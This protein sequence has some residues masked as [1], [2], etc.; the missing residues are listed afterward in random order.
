[1]KEKILYRFGP[2]SLCTEENTLRRNNK[3]IPATPKMV[4]LLLVLL[5][6]QG[7]VLDKEFLLENV[8]P[9]SFVEEGNISFNIRQLRKALD[10]NAQSPAFIE[11]VP[12]RGYRFIAEVEMDSSAL[13]T[14]PASSKA[15][16]NE[17]SCH[18][19]GEFS[20]RT[21]YPLLVVIILFLSAAAIGSFYLLKGNIDAAPVLSAPFASEKLSTTGTVFGSAIS[22]DG[23]TVVFSIRTGEKQSVWLR[24]LESGTNVELIP[25]SEEDYYEFTYSPDGDW[26]YFSRGKRDLEGTIEIFRI[27]I[28]GGI[29]EKVL[30]GTRG[31]V[32]ISPDGKIISFVRCPMLEKEWCSLYVADAG[33]GQNER[34]LISYQYPI[35]IADNE[36]SPDGMRIAYAYGQS[37]NQANAFSI[38]EIDLNEGTEKVITSERFF[39][40]KNICWLPDGSGLLLSA[41]RI[42]NKHFRI[43]HLSSGTETAEPL[44]NDSEAYSVLSLDREAKKLIS[45]QIKQDFRINVF[46]IED[47]SEKYF[48]TDASRA[49]FA[50]D[51]KV[52]FASV[53]SGNDEIWSINPDGSGRRQLTNDPGGDAAPVVSSDNK[54]VF[55]T[56]NRSGEAHVWK[57]NADGTDQIQI[58][59][60]EGGS[61]IFIAPDGKTVY[62]RHG[63][64]GTLWSVS[65]ENGEERLVYDRTKEKIA[66]SPDGLT[67]AFEKRIDSKLY[68]ALVSLSS[69]E[70]VGAIE[71]PAEKTRLLELSWMPDGRSILFMM[72]NVNFKGNVVYQY[73]FEGKT[74]RRI[75]DLG[76]DEV[77]E[78]SG[79]AVSPDG[80]SFTV[81]QGGWKHDAVLITGLR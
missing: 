61:P 3:V 27:S 43:W 35:R 55:F 1:M 15:A 65:V 23:K 50:S 4:E 30:S 49:T 22:P 47:P 42:P 53:M 51:G 58:T 44:T 37:R 7:R 14:I 18:S 13:G 77:S 31:S 60:K 63:I 45:T 40:I 29:P 73:S 8:W 78:V 48:L 20:A 54:T 5:E 72:S 16:A 66:I 74:T 62:Y 12:R 71:L 36:F 81:V 76:D 9:D 17:R 6:N 79:I 24:Q 75:A 32:S 21:R 38:A 68:L 46:N 28:L 57:M 59:S 67:M 26:I 11:T 64:D 56:S 80:K 19:T 2:F 33:S 34:K 69:L 25:P 10:D 70:T 39:N 52:Y 41:S